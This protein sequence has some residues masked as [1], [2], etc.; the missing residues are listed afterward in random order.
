MANKLIWVG[1]HFR[2][3][4]RDLTRWREGVFDI[5][6][7]TTDALGNDAWCQVECVSYERTDPKHAVLVEILMFSLDPDMKSDA[8]RRKGA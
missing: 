4:K 6:Q 5:E 1:D 7:R 3:V 8:E 2:I